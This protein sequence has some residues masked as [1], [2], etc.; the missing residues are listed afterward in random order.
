MPPRPLHE[1]LWRLYNSVAGLRGCEQAC[2]PWNIDQLFCYPICMKMLKIKAKIAWESI[3]K[4]LDLPRACR[5]LKLDLGRKR[6]F[7][8]PACDMTLCACAN[9]IFCFPPPYFELRA[10]NVNIIFCPLPPMKMLDPL[11]EDDQH[12]LYSSINCVEDHKTNHM[13]FCMYTSS[14][15]QVS[16]RLLKSDVTT[17]PLSWILGMWFT[18][19]KFR[20]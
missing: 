3:C 11:L 13:F 1:R 5:V 10:C 20:L 17:R 7:A 15:Y 4:L 8:L 14:L 2:T 19:C 6:D 18:L 12:T 9:T 16:I